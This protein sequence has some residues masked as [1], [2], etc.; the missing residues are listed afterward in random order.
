MRPTKADRRYRYTKD[1]L[2]K[3]LLELM[4]KKPIEEVTITDI[5][6]MADINRG[7]FYNHYATPYDLLLEMQNELYEKIASS[8][9]RTPVSEGGIIFEE[10][11]T[12][13]AKDSDLFQV[14]L[15]NNGDKDF[16]KKLIAIGQNKINI[17]WKSEHNISDTEKIGL[18]Y[19]FIAGGCAR[20]TE[21]WI[22]GEIK[23]TPRQIAEL[24][25][26]IIAYVV[27][28]LLSPRVSK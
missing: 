22:S 20:V 3:S 4:K 26:Q 25:N 19:T 10:I 24:V 2:R 17:E 11:L 15:S 12:L 23:K 7:T 9:E 13:I 6:K 14:L 5:C 1:I 21:D 27:E 16:I 28:D 8:I 18:A